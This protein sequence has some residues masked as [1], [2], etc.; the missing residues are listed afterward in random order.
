MGFLQGNGQV[1][2]NIKCKKT[3]VKKSSE[4]SLG[5]ISK[6]E[7]K[8]NEVEQGNALVGTSVNIQTNS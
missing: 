7:T 6:H 5:F 8:Q 3:C 4:H 2:K 1:I